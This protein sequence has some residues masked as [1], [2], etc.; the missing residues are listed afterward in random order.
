V[1]EHFGGRQPTDEEL[2]DF[3]RQRLHAQGRPPEEVDDIMAEL[4]DGSG[5]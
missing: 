1:E 5:G 2:R 4:D 3:L